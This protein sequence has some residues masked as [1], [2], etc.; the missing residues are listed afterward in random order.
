MSQRE[1]ERLDV[2]A[3]TDLVADPDAFQ[4]ARSTV[5]TS[6]RLELTDLLSHKSASR[7]L[8]RFVALVGPNASGRSNAVSAIRLLREIAI[9]GL[10]ITL[11]RRGGSDQLRHRSAA[12]PND[13]G[14]R[15]TLALEAS[16][17]RPTS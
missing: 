1:P 17:T 9:Y 7:D 8:G 4:V 11:A 2:A 10:P 12:R 15:L 6:E 5:P 3:G 16:P 14:L 13:P